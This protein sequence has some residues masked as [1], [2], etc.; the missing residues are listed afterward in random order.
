MKLFYEGLIIN[1]E[2][3]YLRELT[4]TD[5]SN[6]YQNWLADETVTEFLESIQTSIESLKDYIEE[7]KNDPKSYLLG[8][9]V[10]DKDLHIGNIKLEPV[11]LVKNEC[12]LGI[13]LG[14]KNYWRQGIASEAILGLAKEIQKTNK[15]KAIKL[16]VLQSNRPAIKLYKKIGF[17]V[18]EESTIFRQKTKKHE[19]EYLMSLD[20]SSL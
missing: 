13:M 9:F 4:V 8:I 20:L 19:P 12:I 11:D 3:L 6:R 1:T 5:A 10:R 16:G 17:I 14:D 18:I 7:K 2:R 15:L